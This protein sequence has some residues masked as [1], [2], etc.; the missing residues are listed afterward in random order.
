MLE[1]VGADPTLVEQNTQLGAAVVTRVRVKVLVVLLIVAV[2]S[3]AVPREMSRN[4]LVITK[5]ASYPASEIMDQAI[6]RTRIEV[7]T[8]G[9]LA[10]HPLICPCWHTLPWLFFTCCSPSRAP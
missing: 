2:V 6:L 7:E 4:T 3:L 8:Q 10:P 9:A 1:L 5:F